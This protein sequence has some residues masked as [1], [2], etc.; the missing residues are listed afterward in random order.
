M[1]G[2]DRPGSPVV[3]TQCA[4]AGAREQIP[5]PRTKPCETAKKKK[6]KHRKSAGEKNQHQTPRTLPRCWPDLTSCPVFHGLMFPQQGMWPLM[7]T[8]KLLSFIFLLVLLFSHELL[9]LKVSFI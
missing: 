2:G 6:K 4:S 3:R 8:G 7:F 1:S 9:K 5:G